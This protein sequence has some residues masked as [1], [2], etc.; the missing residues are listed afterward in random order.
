[1]RSILCRVAAVLAVVSTLASTRIQAEQPLD[2]ASNRRASAT[3]TPAAIL[4]GANL[5][6]PDERARVVTEMEAAEKVRY[7]AVLTKARQLGVPVRK[8]GP[9]HQVAILHSFRGD[10]PIYRKTMNRNAAIS[11]A[12]NLVGPAPYNLNGTGIKVGVWDAG[13]VRRTHQEFTLGRVTNINNVATDD[14]ATHV[15][16][17][18][19]AA[20][21]TASARGMA[22]NVWIASYDWNSDYAEMTAAG[23]ATA[24]QSNKVPI[25][26]HSYGYNATTADMGVYNEEAVTMDALLVGLPYY[27]PFWAAGNEQ[28]EL[29]AKGGYQSITYL[30]L[31]KNLIT[32]GAVN[33]AVSG[34]NRSLGGATIAY[35]SSLG[36]SDDGRIKPDV[37][38]NG[39]DLN[40]TVDTSDTAY[41]SY[42]G[43]SM[44][45]PSASGSAALLAQLYRREFA[46]Q[47]MRAS[48]LKGLLI[49]TADD[50]GT[51]GPDYT[52]GWGLINTKAAADVILAHKNS[53]GAPKMI[54][55]NLT[56]IVTS[57]SF[58][59]NWDGTSPIRATLAW[60][61]PAGTARN[62]NDRNPVLVNNLDLRIIAPN[63]TVF[64][65]YVMPFSTNFTDANFGTAAIKGSNRVDN[66]ER[67]DIPTPTIPGTYNVVVSFGGSLSG[68]NP[69]T[70]SLILTGSIGT[71]IPPQIASIDPI[72][73]VNGR[74]V[75]F[76]ITA[77]DPADSDPI[78][79]TSANLPPGS[80]FGSTNGNGSF[81]WSVA[82]PNGA[83]T[84][85]F[86]ATD[87]DGSVTQTVSITVVDNA[88]PVIA[89]IGDKTTIISNLL[90]F[91]VTAT[92]PIGS[93]PITL[94]ASNLPAG[95]TFGA[96]NGT[97][98]FT[99][100]NP[101]PVG[102]Y[103][104]TFYAGDMTGT[105]SETIY[106]TVKPT[107]IYVYGTNSTSI[108]IPESGKATPYPSQ[109]T[110][111]GAVGLVE[112][113]IVKLNNFSH[114]YP[115][116]LDIVLVGPQGQKSVVMGAVGGASG[117]VNLNLNFDD[118]ADSETTV[119]LAS[120]TWKP[121]GAILEA[122]P[123]P[124]P[125]LPYEPSFTN[126]IGTAPNGTWSLYVHDYETPDN[127][128]ISGGWSLQIQVLVPTNSAPTIVV[129]NPAPVPVGST[130]ELSVTAND[131]TDNDVIT[132]SAD[133][134]PPGAVFDTLTNASTVTGTLVWTNAG[135]IGAYTAI[136]RATDKDGSRTVE[137]PIQVFLPPPPAPAPLWISATNNNGFTAEWGSVAEAD[138]YRL[139]VSP[140]AA[141][142]N[143]SEI[144]TPTTVLYHSGTPGSG[145]GGTWLE[146]IVGG[147]TYLI[148]TSSSSRV[149]S[150]SA[151]FI[152]GVTDS[153]TFQARTFGGV[154]VANNT[155]TVSISTNAGVS[156]TVLGTRIPLS[157]TLTTMA[158]FD[159]GAYDGKQIAVKFETLGAASGR[160]AG[161]R[162]IDLKS[163]VYEV[164][165]DYVSGYSN[166][167]VNTTSEIVTN[168][169]PNQTY[170]AR[171]R[172][173][174]DGGASANSSTASVT[175]TFS[176]EPPAFISSAGPFTNQTG[177]AFALPVSAS[178]LPAPVITLDATT[179]SSGYS[180]ADNTLTY[181]PPLADIGERTFTLVASNTVGFATQTVTVVVTEG[182]PPPPA[183][184]WASATNHTDFTAS[185][186]A[187]VGATSYRLDVAT[188]DVFVGGSTSATDLFLSE[189]I[190]GS[191]NNKAI[192][193]FNGTGAPVNL[194]AGGYTIRLYFNGNTSFT[195]ITLTGTVA[196]ADVFVIANSSANAAILAQADQTSGNVT[197]NGND[198]IALAK[199]G[200][201][202]DVIGTIGN[203]AN[204]AADVTLVRESSVSAG[205]TTYAPAE[206]SSQLTDT[207]SFLGS[208]TYAGG[209]GAPAY[210]PGYSNL[211]V[212]GT[213]QIVSGLTE[214]YTYYF[215]ARAVNDE[216]ESA[217]SPTGSVT[218]TTSGEPPPTVPVAPAAI[219]ASATNATEFTAA[220]S[221]VSNATSYRL[222]VSTN[223]LFAAGGV[224]TQST[225]AFN[226]A[227]PSTITNNGWTGTALSG[228]GYTTL[229]TTN[230]SVLSP[231]FSTEGFTN[232]TV[233]LR[234]RTFGGV[235][236]S[237]NTI[238]ISLSTNDGVAWQVLGTVTPPGNTFT[239][240]PRLTNTTLLGHPQTRIRWQTLGATG[241]IGAGLSNLTVR[242]WSSGSAP[243]L[244]PGFDNLTV[245]G[246]SQL[247]T[248]LTEGVTY[249]F[250][251][252]AVNT[253]GTSPN[254]PTGS[255]ITA[256]SSDPDSDTDG[257][258][259]QWE[260]DNFGSLTNV[261]ASSDW[262]GDGFI[263]LHEFL[264]GTE[265]TNSASYLFVDNSLVGTGGG[266]GAAYRIELELP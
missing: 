181:T 112:R 197:H 87:K 167:T 159:L 192:E 88:P 193:I 19:G 265:P 59:F 263:D 252:R 20:G 205:T 83:Y 219:W 185:W 66:V 201:N 179:A 182:P 63:S 111:A 130:F 235:N 210:V 43:T 194:S 9:G 240:M 262:D 51:A 150:P 231:A 140:S 170:Y 230:S 206:W 166:R 21:F 232:L 17:T 254:S 68:G 44:A 215:R 222:D 153:L 189:Y 243:S 99:W 234:S 259:D 34:T 233:D 237:A 26:N 187:V 116:D 113:V 238:T 178:G 93:D 211:T 236:A 223:S 15:A 155:I 225:L 5:K 38:A 148:M 37:V 208:H 128:N 110:I 90:T 151:L 30:G 121:S 183:A 77:T 196:A 41:D 73:V 190:E 257:I 39:I 217:N 98:T 261:N 160:G 154:N 203:S 164:I 82:T 46:G 61:D 31:A 129:T 239:D 89:P 126:F 229:L 25:S 54:E 69:Q 53:P 120:G 141:F 149:T 249:Y 202:I 227:M 174:N 146:Q 36:P 49:H 14:H 107:P 13:S 122:I 260:L 169:V 70:F 244:V 188:N 18:I 2:Q 62:D 75:A 55:T 198:V 79:M 133:Q 186:S 76:P 161:I 1:M 60:T 125:G 81:T 224:S 16:G 156:W 250:R 84:P 33:D 180:F 246:T 165:P 29:T 255:V 72:T 213:S 24:T 248:G 4:A 158:P 47:F 80:T 105:V 50:L 245:V 45:T 56:T 71:D 52:F 191:S 142:E 175:T 241:S 209:A 22:T 162:Q 3:R 199:N 64:L 118:L 27:L 103:P 200:V 251:A 124:A 145:T 173:V 23:A 184:I 226:P 40:S 109:I 176:P 100:A 28:D 207:T 247:V 137:V 57:R 177:V 106:I 86:I 92:D 85:R 144:G 32:I 242:G 212:V 74:A 134:L 95:A 11:S 214:D 78:T 253:E 6:N 152:A 108:T 204:F 7:E 91:A 114:L 102:V 157:S 101:T 127:G 117:V 171:V 221:A 264:A 168:L 220:W 139:D 115:A 65:P 163:L 8:D 119:P 104:V 42:S 172:A 10:E 228:S 256:A 266:I 258:P 136:F 131:L 58:P 195:T 67:V 216:G 218:T 48:M 123:S 96:T 97:G 143:V 147:T 94:T 135:P 132:L 138:S 35:F 12:A